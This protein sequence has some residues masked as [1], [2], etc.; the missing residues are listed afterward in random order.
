[1]SS[2]QQ[3]LRTDCNVHVGWVQRHTTGAVHEV[4][5]FG[6]HYAFVH[7]CIVASANPQYD[8]LMSLGAHDYTRLTAIEVLALAT[9]GIRINRLNWPKVYEFAERYGQT[10]PVSSTDTNNKE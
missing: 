10:T 4:L 9:N 6:F 8:P 1:M 7:R 2:N 5:Q 3:R